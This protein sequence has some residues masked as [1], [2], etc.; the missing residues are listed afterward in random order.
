MIGYHIIEKKKKITFNQYDEP[1]V[2]DDFTGIVREPSKFKDDAITLHH[3]EN[4]EK[5]FTH[6]AN[7]NISCV[8]PT[9]SSQ[10]DTLQVKSPTVVKQTYSCYKL[11]FR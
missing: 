9:N 1:I 10:S 3:Y 8:A 2:P 6:I 11:I 7:P 4:G 5:T